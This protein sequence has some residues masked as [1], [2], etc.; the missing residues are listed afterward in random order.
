MKLKINEFRI[1]VFLRQD[2]SNNDAL[3]AISKL[4]D[5]VAYQEN[6]NLHTDNEYKFYTY[7]SLYPLAK[8][9][10]YEKGKVYSII[11]RTTDV[12]V[13]DIFSITLYKQD[14]SM[15]KVLG[16]ERRE[17]AQK[18]LQEIF[19]ITP[20]I[21][22]FDKEGYWREHHSMETFEGRLKVNLVK[23][24]NLIAGTKI[25]ENF[26]WIN[27]IEITNRKPIATNY[28][29]IQLLGDKVV[30]KVAQNEQAQQI[31]WTA[32]GASLGELSARGY[33]FVNYRYL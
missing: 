27:Y 1:K 10:V 9:G 7:N 28:K 30:I 16:V 13:A 25:D 15:F 5:T 8:D 6:K 19:S 23:K 4:F 2:L 29:N 24:Y 12:A 32:V 3:Q 18:P 20:I 26:D 21:V 33:G 14:N 11:V 31:A 22:R 17:I